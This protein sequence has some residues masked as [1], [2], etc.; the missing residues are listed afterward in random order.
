MFTRFEV[1]KT[2]PFC[3]AFLKRIDFYKANRS[4]KRGVLWLASFPVRCDW[5][6]TSSV[7]WK[8]SA[9][10]HVVMPCPGA[11]RQTIKPTINEAFVAF[12][13]DIITDYNSN[14]VFTANSSMALHHYVTSVNIKKLS[15][16]VGYRMWGSCR[17]QI[18]YSLFSQQLE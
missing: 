5:L 9:P 18:V 15:R 2:S 11:T 4:E 7:W 3:S 14:N 13:E 10:Y 17:C 8:C 1:Q 12:S 16:L 6:N